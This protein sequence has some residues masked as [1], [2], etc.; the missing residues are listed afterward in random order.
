MKLHYV[1]SK[2]ECTVMELCEENYDMTRNSII[3][4]NKI[5]LHLWDCLILTVYQFI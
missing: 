3:Y 2:K 5:T 1:K 4:T